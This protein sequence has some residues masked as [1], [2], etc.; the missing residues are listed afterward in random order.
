M[1]KVYLQFW[2]LSEINQ[3]VKNDGV[4]LHLTINDCKNYINQFYKKRVGKKVP[5]KYSRIVGEPILVE[6]TEKLFK[7]VKKNL[8]LK[9][10]SYNYNNLLKLEDIIIV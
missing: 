1:N 3:E 6:I 8:N 7:L 10:R 2:E 9:I 4:S 5:S